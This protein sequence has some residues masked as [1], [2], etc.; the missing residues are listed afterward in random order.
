MFEKFERGQGESA[1]PGVG[2]GLAIC[3]AIVEAHGG[4]IEGH[5]REAEGVVQGAR[6]DI[7]LPCGTPPSDL[8]TAASAEELHA[9]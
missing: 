5:N 3:R 1:T 8:G 6:F 2:L 9:P 4:T 7:T